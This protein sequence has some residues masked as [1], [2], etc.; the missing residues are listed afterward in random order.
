[1]EIA[2]KRLSNENRQDFY[3]VHSEQICGGWCFCTAWWMTTW[4][5][6]GERTSQENRA[7]REELFANQ[8]Y[9]GYVVYINSEPQGWCQVGKRDQFTLLMNQFSLEPDE[10]TWAITCMALPPQYQG[11]GLAHKI[12]ALIIDD[13]K[14]KGVKRLQA[15][16]KIALDLPKEDIWTGPLSIFEKAGFKFIMKDERRFV[17]ELTL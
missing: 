10:D 6:F 7:L 14:S 13:L 1:M 16:P 15:Y 8:I 12:L 2:I 11:L 5:G 4:E 9:D 17:L 3:Q